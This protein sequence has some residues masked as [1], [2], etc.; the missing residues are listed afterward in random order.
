M[1]R[2]HHVAEG[3]FH[4][5]AWNEKLVNFPE[6][7]LM[8]KT[9]RSFKSWHL[10]LGTLPDHLMTL[11][12]SAMPIVILTGFFSGMVTSVQAAYQF[13]TGFIPT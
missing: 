10:Y 5:T 6:F 7:D 13:E 11:G 8:L 4:L 2:G 1:R 9:F 3:T 12:V